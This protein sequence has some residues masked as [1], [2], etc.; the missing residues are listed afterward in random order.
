MASVEVSPATAEA[1]LEAAAPAQ[2]WEEGDYSVYLF[3]DNEP[4]DELHFRIGPPWAKLEIPNP[5][6][7]K[8]GKWDPRSATWLKGRQHKHALWKS[9]HNPVAMEFLTPERMRLVLRLNDVENKVL[10]NRIEWETFRLLLSKALGE[11]KRPPPEK[12]EP[13][14]AEM[15]F[16]D[17]ACPLSLKTNRVEK[18]LFLGLADSNA[19]RRVEQEK[20]TTW[21]DGIEQELVRAERLGERPFPA[22]KE[23]EVQ[24]LQDLFGATM[25]PFQGR[26]LRL[27]ASVL[28]GPD[29]EAQAL[30]ESTQSDAP[31]LLLSQE[32]WKQT[33]ALLEKAREAFQSEDLKLSQRWGVPFHGAPF[34]ATLVQIGTKKRTLEITRHSFKLRLREEEVDYFVWWW[35]KVGSELDG[36]FQWPRRPF[37]GDRMLEREVEDVDRAIVEDLSKL[38]ELCRTRPAVLGHRD[39]GSNNLLR[40]AVGGSHRDAVAFLLAQGAPVES[41]SDRDGPL[42]YAFGGNHDPRI[43]EMLLDAGADP[44][45]GRPIFFAATDGTP[46]QFKLLLQAGVDLEAVSREGL[47]ARQYLVPRIAS[48]KKANL[49]TLVQR[50]TENLELLDQ[51]LKNPYE[52]VAP[53]ERTWKSLP[54]RTRSFPERPVLD[55]LEF[56]TFDFSVKQDVTLNLRVGQWSDSG[57]LTAHLFGPGEARSESTV[58]KGKEAASLTFKAPGEGWEPGAHR[59]IV[60]LDGAEIGNG[61]FWVWAPGESVSAYPGVGNSFQ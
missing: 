21:A 20:L 17:P 41:G 47:T 29:G 42:R 9:R 18:T 60:T 12:D 27:G 59:V 40:V 36:Q 14:Q 7:F 35:K 43:I 34:R 61:G 19:M 32:Q 10:L 2:G 1:T 44:D 38:Q 22:V 58:V 52:T 30:L 8:S 28:R 57:T 25:E 46:E 50:R 37:L 48:A 4:I 49:A 26:K 53:E 31:L 54:P 55:R 51:A 56:E 13:E 11:L 5:S 3:Q 16:K 39:K 24:H 33:E 15:V 6:K 23:P 45:D